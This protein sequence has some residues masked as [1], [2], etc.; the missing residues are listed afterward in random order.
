[1]FWWLCV[2]RYMNHIHNNR[3]LGRLRVVHGGSCLGFY[4]SILWETSDSWWWQM[5]V[6][7]E[8]VPLRPANPLRVTWYLRPRGQL[9]FKTGRIGQIGFLWAFYKVF[10]CKPCTSAS[11]VTCVNIVLPEKRGFEPHEWKRN[12]QSL[13]RAECFS[14]TLHI[15]NYTLACKVIFVGALWWP[16]G[17]VQMQRGCFPLNTAHVGQSVCRG[18]EGRHSRVW[19]VQGSR[20]L[21]LLWHVSLLI[22]P[23]ALTW[24]VTDYCRT[25]KVSSK[26]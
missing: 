17:C 14:W 7:L 6:W 3:T 16:M 23:N 13:P 2:L 4:E 5:W 21:I 1:M 18:S 15:F 26:T 11:A 25:F 20:R 19:T 8:L 24:F 22:K 12:L 9:P 10:W